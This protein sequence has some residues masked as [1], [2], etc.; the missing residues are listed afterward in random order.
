[1]HTI[2]VAKDIFAQF[3]RCER[4][5]HFQDSLLNDVSSH[6]L[7][8]IAEGMSSKPYGDMT[9]KLKVSN[10]S[11]GSIIIEIMYISLSYYETQWSMTYSIK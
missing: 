4:M 7:T 11:K 1:M 8:T 10:R 5:E 9:T 3:K 2:N 6:T